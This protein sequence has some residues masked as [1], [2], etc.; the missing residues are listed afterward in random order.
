MPQLPAA[1]VA[2]AVQSALPAQVVL[3]AP[4]EPQA[5]GSHRVDVTVLQFP[6]PSQVRAGVATSPIVHVAAAQT[7]VVP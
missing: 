2:G 4:F 5:H 3:H 6:A 1:H 7:V